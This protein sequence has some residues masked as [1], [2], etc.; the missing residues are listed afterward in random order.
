MENNN[1]YVPRP[2]CVAAAMVITWPG[3][4]LEGGEKETGHMSAEV[5]YVQRRVSSA[6]A[7]LLSQMSRICL[8]RVSCHTC[9]VV[10]KLTSHSGQ[11]LM[12]TSVDMH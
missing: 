1:Y 3:G 11:C 8:P 9:I 10:Y 12:C 7:I 5:T 6:N 2:G 4:G